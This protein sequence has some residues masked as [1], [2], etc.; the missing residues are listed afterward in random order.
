MA[1][2]NFPQQAGSAVAWRAFLQT[3]TLDV[4]ELLAYVYQLYERERGISA[5]NR[6]LMTAMG[7]LL[8]HNDVTDAA[9]D[10]LTQCVDCGQSVVVDGSEY[11]RLLPC[12][13]IMHS[14]CMATY[15]NTTVEAAAPGCR[16]C[17]TRFTAT[18]CMPQSQ[19]KVAAVLSALRI[20]KGMPL[21]QLRQDFIDTGMVVTSESPALD[22]LLLA[23]QHDETAIKDAAE[24]VIA[25]HKSFLRRLATTVVQKLAPTII[26]PRPFPELPQPTAAATP[27]CQAGLNAAAPVAKKQQQA[28]MPPTLE[29][30]VYP[31]QGS[32]I[33]KGTRFQNKTI[34]FTSF[35]SKCKLCKRTQEQ[36]R[37]IIASSG[38][39][40]FACCICVFSKTSMAVYNEVFGV[41]M[42]SAAPSAAAPSAAAPSAAAAPSVDSMFD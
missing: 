22:K 11:G 42:P 41:T 30:D 26:E 32:V 31:A 35:S 38:D 10:L 2:M 8:E 40:G 34:M 39:Q 28:P 25:E 33:P 36:G 21:A 9:A 4:P 29:P 3:T 20:M 14:F 6:Q 16:Q 18:E 24:A 7:H 23:E 1:L 12:G 27:L 19:I 37:T 13:H 5:R 15:C 17:G